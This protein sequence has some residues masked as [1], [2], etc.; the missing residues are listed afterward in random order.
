MI[1]VND[2]RRLGRAA[3]ENTATGAFQ[4]LEQAVVNFKSRNDANEE[5]VRAFREAAEGAFIE[6]ATEWD[7]STTI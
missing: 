3:G 2:A 5:E 4:R 6:A 1:S 7:H